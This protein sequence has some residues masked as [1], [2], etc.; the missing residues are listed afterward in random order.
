[1]TAYSWV[2]PVEVLSKLM[3]L[4]GRALQIG[5]MCKISMDW[6]FIVLRF[7]NGVVAVV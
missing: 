1:M 2:I 6:V 3:Y 4:K 5:R 7:I